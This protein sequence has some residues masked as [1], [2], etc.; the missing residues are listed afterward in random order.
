MTRMHV[1]TRHNWGRAELSYML[2]VVI[3]SG[4]VTA[5]DLPR[6]DLA[7]CNN[8]GRVAQQAV[9]LKCDAKGIL[10]HVSG[11]DPGLVRI[12]GV[13]GEEARQD[14]DAAQAPRADATGD[15]TDP[16]DSRQAGKCP[17]SP[18]C[19]A[20]RG[21]KAGPRASFLVLLHHAQDLVEELRMTTLTGWAEL[22]EMHS[23]LATKE[24][25]LQEG[26]Q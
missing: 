16:W 25:R 21:P 5:S 20:A 11:R 19:A 14:S 10:E 9:L 23:T 13:D 12:L 6:V 8:L 18:T 26:C 7:L 2:R 15:A 4:D 3:G 22:D 17:R 1:G 24:A